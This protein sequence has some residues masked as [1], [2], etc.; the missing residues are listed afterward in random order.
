MNIGEIQIWTYETFPS[1][2]DVI[3]GSFFLE[4]KLY[5]VTQ[6]EID[7]INAMPDAES[8]V[9]Q[10]DHIMKMIQSGFIELRKD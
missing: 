1:A 10:A 4:G 5:L 3:G 6:R 9:A 7:R 8:V 2:T